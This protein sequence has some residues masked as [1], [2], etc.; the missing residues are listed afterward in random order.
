MDRATEKRVAFL[1]ALLESRLTHLVFLLSFFALFFVNGKGSIDTRLPQQPAPSKLI[2]QEF[3]SPFND[4]DRKSFASIKQRLV[5]TY[6]EF[7]KSYKPGH[8][9]A[10]IDLKGSFGETVY[11]VG[12]GQVLSIFRDF[13]HQ[14]VII[15][16]QL[17]DG[18][19]LFSVY[20]HVEE[21]QVDVG[22]RV[23]EGS[24]LARLFDEDELERANFGTLN[25]LHLEIRKSIADEGRASYASMTMDELNT[26]CIDPM[27][28]F[29]ANC[30]K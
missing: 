1:R 4:S 22:D 6:G 14:T 12:R 9:H 25:H 27:A 3:Y 10:G 8:L 29:R 15:K 11:A 23:N 26:F 24:P 16:H 17:P 5:G 7:R 20:T 30:E 18:N 21:V 13:P 2:C 19:P 28:F